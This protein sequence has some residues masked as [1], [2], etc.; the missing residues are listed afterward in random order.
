ML[1]H[2]GSV[3]DKGTVQL[4]TVLTPSNFIRQSIMIPQMSHRSVMD[5]VGLTAQRSWKSHG[6]SGRGK[7][8]T[9]SWKILVMEKSCTIQ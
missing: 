5:S 6:K 7:V 9:K 1:R 2:S 8:M 3:N 4:F